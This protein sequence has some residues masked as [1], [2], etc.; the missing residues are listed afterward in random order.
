MPQKSYL[1]LLYLLICSLKNEYFYWRQNLSFSLVK[2][3][4]QILPL[5]K[6]FKKQISFCMVIF[7]QEYNVMLHLVTLSLGVEHCD[8][9]NGTFWAFFTPSYS[10]A[11][12]S[13]VE[14]KLSLSF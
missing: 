4:F 6:Y 2:S 13:R 7:S 9:A 10:F 8:M 12:C 5:I 11:F 3:Y 1:F 14:L